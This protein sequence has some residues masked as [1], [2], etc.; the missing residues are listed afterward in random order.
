M[1][2]CRRGHT[3]SPEDHRQC[4]TCQLESNRRRYQRDRKNRIQ[5]SIAYYQKHKDKKAANNKLYWERHPDKLE[6]HQKRF[7]E[8]N[9]LYSIWTGMNDRCHNPKSHAYENYG[10]RGIHVC[11]EW[12]GPGGYT[13]FVEDLPPRPTPRHTLDRIKN[14]LG[15][16]KENCTWA[17]R[18]EQGSNRRTNRL[19]TICSRTQTL[20]KW[21]N[22]LGMS[23]TGFANRIERGWPE[24]KLLQK[25][26]RRKQPQLSRVRLLER[27]ALALHSALEGI[28]YKGKIEVETLMEEIG[29]IASQKDVS[30]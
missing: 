22:E 1:K 18:E 15:Y 28:E 16:S 2:T 13:R 3:Y 24:E 6:Q 29:L 30:L 8:K 10:G 21:A 20:Q 27:V 26:E 7:R 14:E 11:D 12:R 5:Q 4:P 17:T 23:S 19:I 25:V 9:T